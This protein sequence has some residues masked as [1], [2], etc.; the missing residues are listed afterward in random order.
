[1][2]HAIRS[3]L[4]EIA[5]LAAVLTTTAAPSS[6]EVTPDQLTQAGWTCVGPPADPT[7]LICAP[8]GLGLPRFRA[9]PAL[10]TEIPPT[11]SRKEGSLG[12][13]SVREE[14]REGDERED[15][16]RNDGHELED[17]GK[18]DHEDRE[19]LRG[20]RDPRQLAR[21]VPPHVAPRHDVEGKENRTDDE[22][23]P[24]R[25]VSRERNEKPLDHGDPKSETQ[26]PF[27]QP[28]PHTCAAGLDHRL[29]VRHVINGTTQ[30]L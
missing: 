26:S 18:D 15:Y 30:V 13:P 6:A 27:A 1:M 29:A 4:V 22:D 11:S 2:K 8:P 23:G 3:L 24:L 28:A 10:P 5:T 19:R 16:D 20:S 7:R 9:H 21:D 14:I 12:P 17:E 25:Q